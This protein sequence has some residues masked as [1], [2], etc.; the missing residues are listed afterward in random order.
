MSLP[1]TSCVIQIGSACARSAYEEP[2]C[3]Y[4]MQFWSPQACPTN[5]AKCAT[6]N[7]P[8]ACGARTDCAWCSGD[9]YGELQTL[10]FSSLCN[11]GFDSNTDLASL[12]GCMPIADYPLDCTP[13]P[14]CRHRSHG[15]LTYDLTGLRLA[16]SQ[17]AVR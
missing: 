2:L 3:V 14:E 8:T 12:Q 10:L 6:L 15:G 4:N 1:I 17:L 7:T 13:A 5:L 11:F 16:V 9:P